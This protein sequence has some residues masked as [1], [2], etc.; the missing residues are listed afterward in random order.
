[1]MKSIRWR[2][3]LWY[4]TALTI[5]LIAYSSCVY[6]LIHT[7]LSTELDRRLQ[8]NLELVSQLVE[9][10]NNDEIRLVEED[11]ELKIWDK[12][13]G[14][15]GMVPFGRVD[16]I[17][18]TS[19]N[20]KFNFR[21]PVAGPRHPRHMRYKT[22]S[23]KLDDTAVM[24]RVGISKWQMNE[25]L[26]HMRLVMGLGMPLGILLAVVGGWWLAG[27]VLSPIGHM[28]SQA[29]RISAESLSERLP[30][31]ATCDELGQLA[32]VFNDTFSRLE[33]SF[34]QLRRFTAD[35]SHELRTPLTA[36][37][38]TGEVALCEPR[39]ASEYRETIGSMLEEVALL[40]QLVDKLLFLSRADQNTIVAKLLPTDVVKLVRAVSE[41][42]GVLA[43]EKGQH[44][45]LD[46]AEPVIVPAD[47]ALLRQAFSNLLDNA[48]KYSP[49]DNEIRMTVAK[50]GEE[51]ILE[52]AD[53]GPGIP[54]EHQPHVFERF[55]RV[56][57]SR[58]RELGGYGLGLAITQWIVEAHE[59]HIEIE[60]T[61]GKG[62]VFRI[63][64]PS[65]KQT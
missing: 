46:A 8:R 41:T 57:K 36:I 30:I 55:Y 58:S 27:R 52:V 20:G 43:E 33:Q 7:Y 62:S 1:M 6:V 61:A 59:G 2:L 5:I 22:V 54:A 18:A 60:S 16:F 56:D 14:E 45:R 26:S 38:A 40:T 42:L 28:A 50:R 29:K 11:G 10:K 39:S 24:L 3:T 64:L 35:A 23:W 9:L 53:A 48:I 31:T 32:L 4:A 47:P 34:D 19:K 15:E 37:R 13:G 51:T 65:R 12:N 49:S 21:F 63:V 17:E 25:F 44:L